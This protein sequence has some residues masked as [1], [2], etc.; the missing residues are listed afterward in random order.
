MI[1]LREWLDFIRYLHGSYNAIIFFALLYQGWIG[2]T[3]RRERL[4]GGNRNMSFVGRHRKTGPVL[5]LLAILGYFAGVALVFID[6]GHIF[7]F[8]FHAVTG[9]CIVCFI[10]ITVLISRQ[11]KGTQSP[12]RNPHSVVG[13]IILSLYAIQILLGLNILL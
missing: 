12:W 11:I 3:I 10:T 9:L 2:W 1:V 8:L 7:E 13:L 5:T 4:S 6:K